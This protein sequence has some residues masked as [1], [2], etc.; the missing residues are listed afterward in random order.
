[1]W[2]NR[3]GCGFF[4]AVEGAAQ[5]DGGGGGPPAP[6]G[7]GG[8]LIGDRGAAFAADGDDGRVGEE[9]GGRIELKTR[10]GRLIR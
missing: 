1:M 6:V 7:R 4:C 2:L 3:S 9:T 5:V 8:R 10:G